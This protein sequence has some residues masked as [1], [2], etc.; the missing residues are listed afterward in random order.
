ML[1]SGAPGGIEG[2]KSSSNLQLGKR[3]QQGMILGMLT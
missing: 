3:A 2:G 1:A